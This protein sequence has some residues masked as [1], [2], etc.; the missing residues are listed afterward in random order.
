ML[1]SLLDS[2]IHKVELEYI[3]RNLSRGINLHLRCD[4]ARAGRRGVT[5]SCKNPKIILPGTSNV[6]GPP[7]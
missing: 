4:P 1:K 6:P 7:A 3:S 2:G 5:N